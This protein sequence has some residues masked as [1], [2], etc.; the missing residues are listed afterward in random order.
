M[1]EPIE[2][3]SYLLTKQEALALSMVLRNF[4]ESE[5]GSP[6]I[7]IGENRVEFSPVLLTA[8]SGAPV[9]VCCML[10]FNKPNSAT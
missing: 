3:F 5:L 8:T 4:A 10:S 7:V 9:E 1:L 6:R 2:P